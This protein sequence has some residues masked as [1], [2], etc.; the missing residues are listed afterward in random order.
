MRKGILAVLPALAALAGCVSTIDFTAPLYGKFDRAGVVSKSFIVIGAVSVSSTETHRAGPLGFKRSVE[1]SK[2][3]YTDL[4]LEA[5]LLDADDVID[6]RIDMTTSG[7]VSFFDWL[8]GWERTYTH[9]GQALAVIYAGAD[10]T[11][12]EEADVLDFFRR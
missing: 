11:G 6:V 8:K 1:G 5:A 10:E 3:T 9:S 7:K 4:I 2:I 12:D